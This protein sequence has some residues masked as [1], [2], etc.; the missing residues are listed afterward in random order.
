MKC[1]HNIL[2]KGLKTTPDSECALNALAIGDPLEYVRLYLE[3]NLQ[4]WI[5]AEGRQQFRLSLL[6][7]QPVKPD[8]ADFK[9]VNYL[10][11]PNSFPSG[12]AIVNFL[13]P[14]GVS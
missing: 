12:S 3:G 10:Q 7:Y 2:G 9:S 5:D 1:F 4:I 6:D 14:Q 8:G 13:V 11:K